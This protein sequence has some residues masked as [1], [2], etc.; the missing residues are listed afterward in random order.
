MTFYTPKTDSEASNKDIGVDSNLPF[1]LIIGDSISQ[2]YT[3]IVRE[4]LKGIA[5][6]QRPKTNCGDTLNGLKNL[7]NWLTERVWDVIH[8]N[9]GLHDLCHRHPDSKEYGN[10]D[11]ING[12]ISVK[13]DLYENNLETLVNMML[14]KSK[15]LLWC[16]TS[17]VPEGEAGRHCGDDI[18]YNSIAQKVMS[19]HDIPINDLHSLTSSF[20]EE[21]FIAK[22]DVHFTP[23]GNSLLGK[24]VSDSI[25]Q[26]IN[27]L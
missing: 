5:N 19:S 12:K 14:P 1:V 15:R 23:K 9:W 26:E 17:Y 3:P 18:K 6:V 7:E 21:L 20:S 4:N 24:Q 22:G 2:G 25:L 13:P 8:F 10:R 16:A 27:L 11:K